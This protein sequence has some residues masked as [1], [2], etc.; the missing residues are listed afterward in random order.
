MIDSSLS[1]IMF[2]SGDSKVSSNIRTLIA[3]DA[4]FA[5]AT[6]KTVKLRPEFLSSSNS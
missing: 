6:K 2:R 3:T 5:R 4:V 1:E